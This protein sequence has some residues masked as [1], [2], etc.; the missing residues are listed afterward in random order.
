MRSPK[1]YR[2]YVLKDFG[3]KKIK[4]GMTTLKNT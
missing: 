1:Y 4:R 2:F 3:Y